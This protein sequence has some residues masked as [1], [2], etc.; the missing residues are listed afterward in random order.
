MK[1]KTLNYKIYE[2]CKNMHIQISDL[3]TWH[4]AMNLF[5]TLLYITINKNYYNFHLILPK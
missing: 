5:H 4:R 2:I 3:I 1:T